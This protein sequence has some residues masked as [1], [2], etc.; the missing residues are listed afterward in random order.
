[1]GL[2]GK[3]FGNRDD[4]ETAAGESS[5]EGSLERPESPEDPRGIDGPESPHVP[6]PQH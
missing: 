1:M 6:H 3:I 5:E 2:L 4:P